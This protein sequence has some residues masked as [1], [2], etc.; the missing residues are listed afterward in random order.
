MNS[1]ASQPAR[2]KLAPIM[3]PHSSTYATSFTKRMDQGVRRAGKSGRGG[4]FNRRRHRILGQ[5]QGAQLSWG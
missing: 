5:S 2:A 1:H 4:V 3:A